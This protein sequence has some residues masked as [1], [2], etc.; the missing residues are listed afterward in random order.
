MPFLPVLTPFLAVFLLACFGSYIFLRE[1]GIHIF[2]LKGIDNK[3]SRIRMYYQNHPFSFNHFKQPSSYESEI[4]VEEFET[5][6]INWMAK[7]YYK[8]EHD[9]ITE[10]NNI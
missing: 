10:T 7:I 6:H 2:Y 3:T 9:P 8:Q 5:S 4:L 1:L